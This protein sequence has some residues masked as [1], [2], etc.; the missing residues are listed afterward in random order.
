MTKKGM[1]AAVAS[2]VGL[3]IF[4]LSNSSCAKRSFCDGGDLLLFG[5]MAIGA[6]VPAYFIGV[7]F[8]GEPERD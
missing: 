6:L 3:M 7:I 8:F 1:L 2:W 5:V 4:G